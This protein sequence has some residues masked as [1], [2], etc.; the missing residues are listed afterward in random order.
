MATL[1]QLV[2]TVAK[3]E[4]LDPATVNLIARNLREARLI[5]TRGRGTSAAVMDATDAANLLIAVNASKKAT[6]APT[7]VRTFGRLKV[8]HKEETDPCLT[9]GNALRTLLDA[10]ANG[11]FPKHYLACPSPPKIIQSF[12]EE[13]IEVDITFYKPT[14]R[15]LLTIG[16]LGER[17]MKRVGLFFDLDVSTTLAD[18][19]EF[20]FTMSNQSMNKKTHGD[21]KNT[22]SISF[23]TIRA[24]ADIL[25]QK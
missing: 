22:T 23:S 19:I 24:V 9:F 11:S 21:Q 4:G 16:V 14:P 6:D 3:V 10:A 25:R 8:V 20:S 15:V 2:E 17:R 5:A 12:G 1:T 7:A 18:E 13:K